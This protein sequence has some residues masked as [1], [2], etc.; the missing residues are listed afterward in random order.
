VVIGL[1]RRVRIHVWHDFAAR[2]ISMVSRDQSKCV[3]F[4]VI[5]LVYTLTLNSSSNVS[6]GIQFG[7]KGD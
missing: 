1:G 6:W 2:T 5:G 3:S 7:R 4:I